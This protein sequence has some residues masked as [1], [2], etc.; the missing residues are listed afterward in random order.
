[1]RSRYS[2]YVLGNE[3]YLKASWAT[4]TFPGALE[5]DKGPRWC[6]LQ[7]VNTEQGRADDDEGSVEFIATYLEGDHLGQLHELSRFARQERRWVY[8]DGDIQP[9]QAPVKIARNEPCPCGS[10][11]KFKRCCAP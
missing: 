2:A 6:G 4:E 3:D 7:I 11:K 5:L 8:V 10:G 9:G 1:M